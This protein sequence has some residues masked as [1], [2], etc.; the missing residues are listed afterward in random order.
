MKEA[1]AKLV[2]SVEVNTKHYVELLSRVV[3]DL[4]KTVEPSVDIR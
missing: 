1:G 4:L 3:D 2:E